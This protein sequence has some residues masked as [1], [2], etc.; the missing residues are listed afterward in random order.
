[1]E[2]ILK[3]WVWHIPFFPH[4][5]KVRTVKEIFWYDSSNELEFVK[6]Q[7]DLQTLVPEHLIKGDP[8]HIAFIKQNVD[9]IWEYKKFCIYT[10]FEGNW[11]AALD[12]VLPEDI[13]KRYD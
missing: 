2:P 4:Y 9:K 1:M 5:D 8:E 10:D 6:F 13:L 3:G 12:I 7:Y 11:T